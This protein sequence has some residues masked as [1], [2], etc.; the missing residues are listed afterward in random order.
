MK[1]IIGM[2]VLVAVAAVFLSGCFTTF[3]S[4]N[5]KLA[6]AD[7]QGT[8]KGSF[9]YSAGFV[10]IIH[11]QLITFGG[12]AWE[13][14]DMV[15][16]GHLAQKGANAARNIELTHGATF[17]NMLLSYIVPVVSWGTWGVSGTAIQQ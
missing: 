17:I 14:V 9:E 5:G 6:Y 2:V 7:V 16:E 12:R 4:T 3:K 8:D 11:P 13:S 1:K 15:L 10:Y